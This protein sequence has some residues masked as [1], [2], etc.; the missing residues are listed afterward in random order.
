VPDLVPEVAEQGAVALVHLHAHLFARD[1]VSLFEVE[2]DDAVR[3]TREHRLALRGRLELECQAEQ[4]LLI[5][6][7]DR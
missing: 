5:A 6:R 1:R 7:I 4:T 2:R 3:V